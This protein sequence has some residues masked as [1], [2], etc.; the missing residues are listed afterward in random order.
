M[1]EHAERTVLGQRVGGRLDERGDERPENGGRSPQQRRP[2]CRRAA[3]AEQA[4]AAPP[5]RP[6]RCWPTP[7]RRSWVGH[8]RRVGSAMARKSAS[9]PQVRAAAHQVIGTDG[10]VDPEPAQDEGEDELG[11]QKRLHHRHRP[12]VQ[13]DGLEEERAGERR[14]AEQPQR[15]GHEVADEP[16]ALGVP[17]SPMLATCCMTTLRALENAA[18]RANRTGTEAIVPALPLRVVPLVTVG[19][20]ALPGRR[21]SRQPARA[22]QTQ[23]RS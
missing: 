3:H 11:D 6:W 15:V 12:V 17:G 7:R 20:P 21:R 16:P 5:C 22:V 18:S 9:E 10:L 4:P 2:P 19:E 23:P 8:C 1:G 13:G 14:P